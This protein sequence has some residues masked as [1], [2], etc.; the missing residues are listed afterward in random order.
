MMTSLLQAA[1]DYAA[2]GWPVIPV[3]PREKRPLTPHGLKDASTDE[4]QI[5]R[6]WARWPNANIGVVTGVVSGLL[7]VDID[8]RDG[9]DGEKTIRELETRYGHLPKTAEALTGGNGRHLFFQCPRPIR[10]TR[11]GDGLD[12]KA[13]GGYIIVPPSIHPSG[14]PYRW[15]DGRVPSRSTLATPPEWLLELLDGGPNSRRASPQ[16]AAREEIIPAG[17]RNDTLTSIAGAMRRRGMSEA[18]I[19]AALLEENARRCVPPLPEE[20]VA[21][22][23]RSIARYPAAVNTADETLVKDYGHAAILATLFKDHY[24]WAVHRNV[25]MQYKAG[26]W[27]PVSEE[28][29]AKAAA[30]ILRQYYTAKLTAAT[31]KAAVLDLTKKIA[32][33]CTY[34]RIEGALRFLRGWEDIVTTAEEWDANPWLLNVQNGTID[35]RTFTLHPHSP[36]DL[37]T[38]QANA[39][40]DPQFSGERWRAH[41][42]MFLPDSDVR[43][44]VQR[45]LGLSLVGASLAEVLPI[46]YGV[47]ANG[48]S[49]T[50]RAVMTTLGDYAQM[51]APKLLMQS[52]YERHTTELAELQGRR[53]VFSSETGAGGRLDEERVKW[54]TGG[55]NIRARFMRQDNIEFQRSWIIIL[56]TNH[57]PVIQGTDNGIW[58]R[59]RLIPWDV[60]LPPEMQ[61]PQE[62]VLQELTEES[63]AILNWLMDGL[64]DW[65]NNPSWVADAVRVATG[66]YQQ[67][68]D[69]LAGFL[70]DRCE[71]HPSAAVG[72]GELYDAYMKWCEENGEEVLGKRAFGERLREKGL[73]QR[74]VAHERVRKWI[75]IRLRTDADKSSI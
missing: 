51:A 6:W 30:D 12:V 52:K 26:V 68:Q 39:V 47:G 74:R 22:I 21:R 13:D 27:R 36:G 4:T 69:R 65:L 42:E 54:L 53:L 43:R 23:A 19:L 41:I 1:L 45:D 38:K 73:T 11:L 50:L 61:K 5:R 72:V 20:E 44:Q 10:T 24:R 59:I 34:A 29:V 60:V 33:T 70:T 31:D 17:R 16:T 49:T 18:A 67:E 55:E 63:A 14:R 2:Q 46:W 3:R 35:L 48:K 9:T 15:A 75:G 64:R 66:Q 32:E 62:E 58:R 7:V 28:V 71:L 37:L 57:K 8:Q 40:Y 25:W 56:V